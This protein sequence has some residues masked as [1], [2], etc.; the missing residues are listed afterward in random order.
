MFYACDVWCIADV[1]S[2][3][4]SSEQYCHDPG[5]GGGDARFWMWYSPQE[6]ET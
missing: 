2:F 6:L 4:P 3:S 1:S 5:E